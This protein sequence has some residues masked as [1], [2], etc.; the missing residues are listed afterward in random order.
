MAVMWLLRLG[1]G[2]VV[3]N[4]NTNCYALACDFENFVADANS[5]GVGAVSAD[6]GVLL[7]EG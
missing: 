4:F 5:A 1:A 6:F 7:V 3:L 2:T